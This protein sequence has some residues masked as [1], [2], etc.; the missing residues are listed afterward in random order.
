MVSE[1]KHPVHLIELS[2]QSV[3]HLADGCTVRDH[4][5]LPKS[6]LHIAA[7]EADL[8]LVCRSD[9]DSAWTPINEINCPLVPYSNKRSVCISGGYIAASKVE[10][11]CHVLS[12]SGITLCHQSAWFKAR[13]GNL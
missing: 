5:C 12:I 8:R 4:G 10:A 3:E 1:G 13:L 6:G 9:F 11:T 2:A 7:R